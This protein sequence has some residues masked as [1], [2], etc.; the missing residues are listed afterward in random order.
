VEDLLSQSTGISARAAKEGHPEEFRKDRLEVL[1][2]RGVLPEESMGCSQNLSP[3]G[4]GPGKNSGRQG[5][6]SH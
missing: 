4:R 2:H 3:V 1:L 5:A 6:D